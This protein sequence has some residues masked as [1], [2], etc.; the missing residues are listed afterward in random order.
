MHAA[1]LTWLG[2]AP[3]ERCRGA[4]SKLGHMH[5]YRLHQ[6]AAF[7]TGRNTSVQQKGET[8]AVEADIAR[9]R[10]GSLCH[11]R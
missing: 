8:C 2:G 6:P 10:N 5:R 3:S 7:H 9:K 11:L 4:C 1:T